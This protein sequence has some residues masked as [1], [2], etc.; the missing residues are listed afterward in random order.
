MNLPDLIVNLHISL[1]YIT[2]WAAIFDPV[3]SIVLSTIQIGEQITFSH[4]K[5]D[6][7][8]FLTS[9][10]LINPLQIINLVEGTTWSWQADDQRPVGLVSCHEQ[11][12]ETNNPADY[13]HSFA[14]EEVKSRASYRFLNYTPCGRSSA[15]FCQTLL[16][17]TLLQQ[18]HILLSHCLF[19]FWAFYI[20]KS[21][22][23]DG[24]LLFWTGLRSLIL[25]DGGHF[26]YYGSY[27]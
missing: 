19:L 20:W 23:R 7:F 2:K 25:V 26:I 5:P 17:H 27:N 12:M 21:D 3:L 14:S 18:A 15:C 22:Q 1:V 8:P 16:I 4:K 9:V 11:Q 10:S 13:I 6:F 24:K